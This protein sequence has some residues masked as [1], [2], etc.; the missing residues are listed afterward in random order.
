MSNLD[1]FSLIRIVFFYFFLFFSKIAVQLFFLID[2][3]NP[4]S[5]HSVIGKHF[6]TGS[7]PTSWFLKLHDA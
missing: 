4:Q 6:E 7:Y 2:S 1:V 3:M 5:Q